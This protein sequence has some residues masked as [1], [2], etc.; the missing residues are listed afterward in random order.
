MDASTGD[1]HTQDFAA[2]RMWHLILSPNEGRLYSGSRAPYFSDDDNSIELL[3]LG[4]VKVH[5]LEPNRRLDTI[6]DLLLC[7]GLV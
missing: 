6:Q 5:Q 7:E 3:P 2:F 4:L 1:P